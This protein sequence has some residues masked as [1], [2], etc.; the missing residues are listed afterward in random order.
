MS[1]L[2][3]QQLI[4][5]LSTF[6]NVP[7]YHVDFMQPVK[8]SKFTYNKNCFI[9]SDDGAD[10]FDNHLFIE[11]LREIPDKNIVVFRIDLGF[12]RQCERID[13]EDDKIVIE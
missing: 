12:C 9:L 11:H 3:L 10:A 8:T 1:Y 7:I 2:T 4:D 13:F 6:P 5:T